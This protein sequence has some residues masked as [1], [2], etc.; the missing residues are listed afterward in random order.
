MAITKEDIKN[1][2]NKYWLDREEYII[3][4][5][6]ALVL[7]GIRETATDID[8]GLSPKAFDR[9][10]NGRARTISTIT[11]HQTVKIDNI[12]FFRIPPRRHYTVIDGIRVQPID[13]IL[14]WKQHLNRPKDVQ[15]IVNIHHK[16][17]GG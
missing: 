15:D 10:C 2:V 3:Y 17:F 11:G 4:T 5:G 13:E 8:V 1:V 6:A 9:I 12:E 16:L 7:M 14:R